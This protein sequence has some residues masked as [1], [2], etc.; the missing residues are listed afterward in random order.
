MPRLD[1]TNKRVLRATCDS[2]A[3]GTFTIPELA[4]ELAPFSSSFRDICLLAD[5]KP[6]GTP[7]GTFTAGSWVVRDL[8]TIVFGGDNIAGLSSNEVTL[9]DSDYLIFGYAVANFVNRHQTRIFNKTT[10]QPLVSGSTVNS[11][12]NGGVSNSL[13]SLFFPAPGAQQVIRIEHQCNTTKTDNGFGDVGFGTQDEQY[14][15]MWLFRVN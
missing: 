8:N 15:V 9:L 6:Q 5:R 12:T 10:G 11:S 14:S 1:C 4:A 2:G 7:G 3:D 13:F